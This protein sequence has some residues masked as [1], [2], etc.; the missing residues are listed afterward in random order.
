MSV[1]EAAA[2]LKISVGRVYRAV[3][4]GHLPAHD[5]KG[6]L[7]IRRADVKRYARRRDAWLKLH[8]RAAVNE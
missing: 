3:R 2:F 6:R 4:D 1:I 8:G 7:L 5:V